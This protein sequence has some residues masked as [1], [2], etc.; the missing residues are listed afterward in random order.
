[1]IQI[2]SELKQRLLASGVSTMRTPPFSLPPDCMFE[3]PCSIKWMTIQHTLDLGAFSYA[4][5]GYYFGAVIGRYTSIGEDVQVGRGSHPIGWASTSPVFYQRHREVLDF[6][7]REAA[8]F[9]SNAP[10]IPPQ[11]THIGNDVYI[12]HGA[13]IMPGV[14]IGDGAVVGAGSV[15]TRDVAPYSVVAGT[16]AI[17]R[18]M[19][20]DD[21]TIQRMQETSWWQYA[22][23]DLSGIPAGLPTAFLDFIDRKVAS[24]L[25]P[26]CPRTVSIQTLASEALQE[27]APWRGSGSA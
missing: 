25:R 2:T 18:K 4:V 6:E 20:F 19:R 26:Y 9:L 11:Q 1:M 22:F 3:P 16:P 27:M 7:C 17:V 8:N 13:I 23:W 24:G 14:R 10:Y 21:N 12:G 5:S 15:V